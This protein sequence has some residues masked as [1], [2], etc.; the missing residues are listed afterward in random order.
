LTIRFERLP[1]SP[2][3]VQARWLLDK[4]PSENA[5]GL[6]QLAL[7]RGYD[8][9]NI[10]R[11][12]GL[13]RP[14]RGDLLP[15]MPGFLSELGVPTAIAREDAARILAGHIAKGISEG[16]ITPYEGARFIGY[17]IVCEIWPNEQ[18]PLLIFEA[19]ASDYEDC[20]SYTDR[21]NARR[22]EIEQDIINEARRLLASPES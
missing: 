2:Q 18:H 13:I 19:C 17:D 7:E 5:P 16:Q 4:F 9:K 22:K 11:I 1:F 20:E 14:D 3:L 15:L 8:G 10:R 6:A 12:A 21:P